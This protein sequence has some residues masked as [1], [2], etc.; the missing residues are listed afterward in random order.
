MNASAPGR[1]TGNG[2]TLIELMIVVAILGVLS[3]L[4]LP[5]FMDRVARAQVSEGLQVAAF[6]QEAVQ[7]EW[8]RAGRLPKDNGVAGLPPATSIVGNHVTRIDVEDG[9]ITI[10]Y[11]QRS[12]RF[13]AGKRLTLR[14]AV[15]AAYRAVPVAWVCGH[16]GVPAAMIVKGANRTDVPAQFLPADC[17]A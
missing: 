3:T 17:R 13:L 6:L 12:N 11:G 16:A 14:P 8:R 1:R 10:T 15:V 5:T 2:F 7:Q 4:A 9:A